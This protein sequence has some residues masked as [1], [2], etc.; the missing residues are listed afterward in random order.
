MLIVD[1]KK[2]IFVS[3]IALYLLEIKLRDLSIKLI[4]ILRFIFSNKTNSILHNG[5]S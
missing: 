5:R 4:K 2:N 1:Q 3:F